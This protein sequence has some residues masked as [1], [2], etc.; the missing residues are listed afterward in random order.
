MNSRV[1]AGVE[2]QKFRL[3]KFCVFS[4]T[5][6]VVLKRFAHCSACKVSEA[7][8]K[9]LFL[10]SF[11]GWSCCDYRANFHTYL[12]LRSADSILFVFKCRPLLLFWGQS[13]DAIQRLSRLLTQPASVLRLPPL[14]PTWNIDY[15]FQKSAVDFKYFKIFWI[16]H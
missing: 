9:S 2:L 4:G 7:A 14:G 10:Y 11:P 3:H 8:A 5:N 6:C 16:P 15:D 1:D 12:K 13:S